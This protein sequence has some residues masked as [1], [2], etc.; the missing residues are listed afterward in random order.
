M[1]KSWTQEL[2]RILAYRNINWKPSTISGENHCNIVKVEPRE[3]TET[4]AYCNITWKCITTTRGYHCNAHESWTSRAC[5]K[6][7]H[8]YI[9]WI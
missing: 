1:C 2:A 5:P 7:S 6:P 8:R 3:L 4:L 9:P